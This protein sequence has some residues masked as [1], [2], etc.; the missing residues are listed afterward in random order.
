MRASARKK[1]DPAMRSEIVLGM[2]ESLKRRV[3]GQDEAV[4][5]L[6]RAYEAFKFGMAIPNR[7]VAN[8]LFL[9]PT[10][11]GKTFVVEMLAEVLFGSA[12]ALLKVDCSEYRHGHEIAKL[13]GSPPG[14][15]GH[16]ETPPL[17]SQEALDKHQRDDLKL[18]LVL[19]DEIEKASEDLWN[20]LLG[21]LDKAT[22]TMGN[23]QAVDF[24][25]CI[26]VL[27][28]NLGGR[29]GQYLMEGGMGFSGSSASKLANASTERGIGKAVMEA[30]KR[31][32][33]PEF[34]NRLDATVV[35]HRLGKA[36]MMRIAANELDEIQKRILSMPQEKWF[37]LRFTDAVKE[38]LVANGTDDRNGARPLKR[39]IE[40]AIMGPLVRLVSTS[41][42]KFGDLVEVDAAKGQVTF[43]KIGEAV[44][45][46]EDL[47]EK[48]A[49]ATAAA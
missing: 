39:L 38:Y 21:I 37:V 12:K 6:V 20:L 10:G 45:K 8:L 41:Q 34:R 3:V 46:R 31:K 2:E 24:S 11:S 1:L 4:A 9:G 5:E 35:F 15:V 29:E 49:E 47:L 18:S 14:Y 17:L 7:P 27:T 28:G 32:F 43:H 40:K 13:T 19:F 16:R 44:L 26:V 25:H 22:A 36:E 33:T 30:V 48:V 23:N 42:V